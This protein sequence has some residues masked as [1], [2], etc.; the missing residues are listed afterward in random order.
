MVH[1]SLLPRLTGS[2]LLLV[3]SVT[4]SAQTP[5][6]DTP[7]SPPTTQPQAY[8]VPEIPVERIQWRG[9]GYPIIPGDVQELIQQRNLAWHRMSFDALERAMPEIERWEALGKPFIRVAPTPDDLPQADIPAFP[10]AEGGGMYSFG[11]RGGKVYVVTNLNDS[12]PG[13]F[14]EACEA[15]GPR[16]IVFNVA[17]V[18]HLERP[19]DILAPYITIAGQSAPGDGVCIA[20]HTVRIRTHDV[21][22]RYMRFRRGSTDISN[23]DDSLGGDAIGN[24]IIDHCSVS[25]GNDESLSLYRQMYMPDPSKPDERRRMAVVNNTI[26]WTI[27]SESLDTY[28]HGF[29]ATWGGWNTGFHHNLFAC[30]TGRNPSI[31]S[32]DFN[33]VNNVLFNW[34]HRT[35]DGGARTINVINNYFKP[36]PKTQERLRHRIGKPEGGAWYAAGNVVHGNEQVTADNWN[37]GIQPDEDDP[38]GRIRAR[39]LDQPAPMPHMTIHSAEEAYELVLAYAGATLP[40]RDAVDERAIRQTRTGEVDYVEGQG[41]ITDISQVGGYP[42]YQGQPI[43]YRHNDGIPDWWKQKYGLDLDDPELASRDP[44]NDGYT[45]IEEYLNGT[46]PMQFVDYRDLSNNINP[47]MAGNALSL[48]RN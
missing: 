10:G 24:V 26:Q 35:L 11:G 5:T 21:V 17:G 7:S 30:N 36:G 23:R 4:C 31:S 39:R 15:G 27:I 25:W 43:E 19:I 2:V 6:S 20:G 14:R 44:D 32:R 13:S 45:N 9:T 38:E 41:I 22:I 47:L 40:V 29:G 28:N 48:L 16:I 42:D 8:H 37:G 18:I 3:A 33:F 1:S 34:R 46:D 12:G